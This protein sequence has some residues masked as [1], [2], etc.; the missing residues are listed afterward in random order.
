[1]NTYAPSPSI[2]LDLIAGRRSIRRYVGGRIEPS[3][4]EQL[5]RAATWA[6]SAHN[7]QPWRFV[8]IEEV[9]WKERLAVGM[10]ERPRA[11]RLADGDDATAVAR[12]V[13]RSHA[14]ITAAPLLVLIC[15][16]MAKMDC[17]PDARRRQAEYMMA[18]QSTA[19]ATQNLLLAA[20]AVLCAPL[21]CADTVALTLD[22][23]PDWEPQGLVT[24]GRPAN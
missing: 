1:M 19:M 8:L 14:R 13:A 21:F 22:L 15:L 11:D 17:Y 2:W 6:P 4:T 24:V 12:D 23:P 9:A 16:S 7:R 10:G 3:D 20:H 5:L 18:V